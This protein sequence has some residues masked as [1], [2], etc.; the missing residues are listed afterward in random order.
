MKFVY[1]AMLVIGVLFATIGLALSS[2]GLTAGWVALQQQEGSYLST[3]TEQ[4]ASDGH[5]ITSENFRIFVDGSVDNAVLPAGVLGFALQGTAGSESEVFLGIG[6]ADEVADYLE[7]VEHTVVRSVGTT[8]QPRYR[9]ILGTGT[10]APPGEQEFWTESVEGVGFQELEWELASGD[11]AIVVMNADAS[12]PVDV[13]LRA[14]VRS[15]VIGPAAVALLLVGLPLLVLGIP[16]IVLGASGLGGGTPVG[17]PHDDRRGVYPARLRG[18]L[19][20]QLSRW[21]WLVKWLLAIPHYLVLIVL[22]FAFLVTTIVAGFAILFTGR[23][24]RGLFNFNVGVLRW[25]WRVGFYS[26]SALGT[27]RYPPFSLSSTEYPADFDVEYPEKLSNG[28]VLVKWWLLAL[29][30]LLILGAL[31]GSAGQVWEWDD[32]TP[33]FEARG[34]ISLI[35]ILVLIAAVIL[36]FTGRYRRGLFDFILG[37]NRWVF[38]VIAYVALMRD[39]YPPFRLDQGPDELFEVVGLTAPDE[40]R[41]PIEP[42]APPRPAAPPPRRPQQGSMPAD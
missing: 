2:L 36:L 17:A 28:L 27:D 22:W 9:E 7:G 6:P 24:P 30:H 31:T 15:S 11:W 19:D 29:P 21:L 4:Y 8:F 35:G 40:P 34:G 10:P 23:Y 20:P 14:G 38:R 1:A 16:L 25:S 12:A 18:E 5:A 33:G 39:E 13:G 26:Y 37:I 3:A 42:A 32:Q 41:S